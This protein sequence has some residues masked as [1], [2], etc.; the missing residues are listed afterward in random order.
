M[1]KAKSLDDIQSML[2]ALP[3][4]EFRFD[5]VREDDLTM[6][7]ALRTKAGQNIIEPAAE[8][9]SM[10]VGLKPSIKFLTEAPMIVK[11]LLD[12]LRSSEK[13]PKPPKED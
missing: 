8:S 9:A 1:Y 11:Q 6:S 12:A 13:A 5:T 4:A 7:G 3:M 2:D 10:I